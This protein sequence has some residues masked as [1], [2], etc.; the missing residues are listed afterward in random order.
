MIGLMVAQVSTLLILVGL[1]HRPRCA[2]NGGR[3]I[4]WPR[5]PSMLRISAV[6]SP[7]TNAPGADADLDVKIE[8]GVEQVPAEQPVL[9]SLGDGDVE[10]FDGQWIFGADVDEPLVGAHRVGPDGHAFEHA[11][12][13]AFEHGAVHERARVALVGVANHV[14]R[15]G[16]RL[17]HQLPLHA[18]GEPRA[19]APAQAAG[20]DFGDDLFGLHRGQHLAQRR[21]AVAGDVFLDVFGVNQAAILK[22]NFLLFGEEGEITLGGDDVGGDVVL[23]HQLRVGA[24][25]DEMLLDEFGHVQGR[26]PLIERPFRVDQHHRAEV[27]R[28]HAARFDNFNF[29]VEAALL[30]LG[31]QRVLQRIAAG[32]DAA[33]AGANQYVSAN[34]R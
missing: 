3:G 11:V 4:G 19:A 28:S 16:G 8:S 12:R 21:I 6:S 15:F 27:A 9:V 32:T 7:H 5:R 17:R 30:Q 10:A 1:P 13:V 18:G 26:D 23:R 14:F 22:D 20:F 2:G 29:L 24:A 34:H 25:L 31:S 33:G